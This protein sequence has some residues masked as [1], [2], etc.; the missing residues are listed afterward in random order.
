MAGMRGQRKQRLEIQKPGIRPEFKLADGLD[1]V[2]KERGT[3]SHAAKGQLILSTNGRDLLYS[4]WGISNEQIVREEEALGR[5]RYP[6]ESLRLVGRR[7][8]YSYSPVLYAPIMSILNAGL[9]GLNG[10]RIL[11]LGAGGSAFGIEVTRRGGHYSALDEL[12]ERKIPGIDWQKG[13][14]QELERHFKGKK[15]NAIV[16]KLVFEPDSLEQGKDE[17]AGERDRRHALKA[18]SGKLER[19]GLLVLQ[20]KNG[21]AFSEQELKEAG[22]RIMFNKA[23]PAARAD[24]TY[25]EYAQRALRANPVSGDA[26][27]RTIAAI[28][29]RD[30]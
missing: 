6:E 13:R 15:F 30:A 25:K 29:I 9:G 22:F 21:I 4:R 2:E 8:P 5:D 18:I 14:I 16:A 24:L 27:K 3:F 7:D 26:V 10:K 19:G 1:V 11:E 23:V 12:V 17:W 28:K 20:G